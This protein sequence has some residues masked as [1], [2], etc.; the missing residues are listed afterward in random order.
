VRVKVPFSD[1]DEM[2]TVGND[3]YIL[4]R[5]DLWRLRDDKLEKLP[6]AEGIDAF[7]ADPDAGIWVFRSRSRE[8]VPFA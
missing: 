6:I 7:V 3:V 2:Q 4:A 5:G 1:S 8:L